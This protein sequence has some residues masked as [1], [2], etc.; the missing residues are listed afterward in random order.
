MK[1][2]YIPLEWHEACVKDI[3]QNDRRGGVM[4]VK[5]KHQSGKSRFF[6]NLNSSELVMQ[7]IGSCPIFRCPPC[8]TDREILTRLA[9]L[10]GI[11]EVR[12]SE[13][14]SELYIAERIADSFGAKM[15]L[16]IEDAHLMSRELLRTVLFIR[17]LVEDRSDSLALVLSSHYSPEYFLMRGLP[18]EHVSKVFEIPDFEP[19]DLL[20]LLPIL[21]PDQSAGIE[22]EYQ[23]AAD[24]SDTMVAELR[25]RNVV[26]IGFVEEF[27]IIA[28]EDY[29]DS[30]I[31]KSG[32]DIADKMHNECRQMVQLPQEQQATFPGM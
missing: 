32:S 20:A 22:A 5:G 21:C 12:D 15:T 23:N 16:V 29:P 31:M 26:R 18:E 6:R 10:M 25:R 8:G 28:R 3:I 27:A 1:T 9:R 24:K 4:I 2:P 30:P 17:S 7:E 14:R 13:P 11:D 19:G